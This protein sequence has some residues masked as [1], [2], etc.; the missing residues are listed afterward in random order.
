MIIN[1]YYVTSAF[2]DGS[3]LQASG[4]FM[5]IIYATILTMYSRTVLMI[6]ALN[7]R[8]CFSLNKNQMVAQGTIMQP[9]VDLLC[10][11]RH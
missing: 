6:H 9:A 1:Y 5:A 2:W 8:L 3:V 7:I 4:C 10:M 11:N